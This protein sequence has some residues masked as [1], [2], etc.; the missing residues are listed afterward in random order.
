[1]F[2]AWRQ[3]LRQ[4]GEVTIYFISGHLDLTDNEFADHYEAR[5]REAIRTGGSFVVGDA[6]GCDWM[7]Q[8][9]LYERVQVPANHVRVFHMFEAPRNNMGF[10][11]VGLFTS[12]EERD[13]AMT[14]VS[15]DDIAWVRRGRESSGTAHNVFRRGPPR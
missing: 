13:A 15:D 10:E 4:A 9:Y 14:R 11:T 5:I 1:M 7:A 12:D 8:R 2:P 6:R 3:I